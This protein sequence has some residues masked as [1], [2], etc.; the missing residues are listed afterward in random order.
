[1]T[2]LTSLEA[3]IR[4]TKLIT[5][6]EVAGAAQHIPEAIDV[7]LELPRFARADSR[8]REAQAFRYWAINVY[9]NAAHTSWAL[10]DLWRGGLYY[11]AMV[12]LRSLTEA[13]VQLRYFE[14]R[15]GDVLLLLDDRTVKKFRFKTMFEAVAPGHY[16]KWYGLMSSI[17]HARMGAMVFRTDESTV[18]VGA[19]YNEFLA[20]AV[21]N[22]FDPI[23]LG[24]LRLFPKHFP[25]YASAAPPELE[26]RRTSEVD[27]LQR[28]FDAQVE[29][30]PRSRD[31]ADLIKPIIALDPEGSRE[32][33]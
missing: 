9:V 12:L 26:A 25:G 15:M 30:F 22:Q 33:A 28:A 29:Q 20:S 31:W 21:M 2:A 19:R 3:G 23:L 18:A 11:E 17:A 5:D 13:I 4:A 32:P 16:E 6:R 24:L 7:L 10:T 8:T 14:S 27:W 1:M